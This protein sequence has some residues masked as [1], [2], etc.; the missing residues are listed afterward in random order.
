VVGEQAFLG[1]EAY[2]Q[3]AEIEKWRARCPLIRFQ[4][5]AVQAGGINPAELKRIAEETVAELDA[6]VTF[7]RE[8][9]FPDASEVSEDLYA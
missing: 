8:S 7:A 3:A 6:A 9:P 1:A 2:R 5:F 4:Q